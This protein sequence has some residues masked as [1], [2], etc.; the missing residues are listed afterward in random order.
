MAVVLAIGGL[1]SSCGA[2]V[3]RDAQ[4]IQGLGHQARVAVTAVTAQTGS[5][6]AAVH[7]VPCE[8]LKL[9]MVGADA[10]KIGMLCD[11]ARVA[12]VQHMLG[13]VSCPVVLDPVLAASAGG[14]LLS[15]DGIDVLLNNL[16]PHVDVLTPNLPELALLAGRIGEASLD[17]QRQAAG[18]MALGVGA[19]LI[20]GGH[21]AGP[22]ATDVL[23]SRTGVTVLEGPRFA[24]TRRGTGC[25]LASA[26]ACGLA[27][28]ATLPEACRRAKDVVSELFVGASRA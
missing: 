27:D 11:A 18:L 24:G 16:L 20:K 17:P 12:T 5:G 25:T 9:Q 14:L 1:D 19:V 3:L 13:G 15:P 8:T 26:I 10:I 21:A 7:P 2:G 22:K 4:T 28:G 23:V 6:V